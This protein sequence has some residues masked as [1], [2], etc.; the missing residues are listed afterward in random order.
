MGAANDVEKIVHH[1]GVTPSIEDAPYNGILP[2]NS[3]SNTVPK[4]FNSFRKG[5][6]IKFC[7][8]VIVFAWSLAAPKKVY[9][10]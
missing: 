6:K 5:T 2:L 3:I 4:I 9:A 1:L 7:N 8:S 10:W